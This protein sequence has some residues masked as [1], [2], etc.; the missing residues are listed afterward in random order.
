MSK[1][2]T[3]GMVKQQI[4]TNPNEKFTPFPPCYSFTCA[5]QFM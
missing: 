3:F 1:I 5:F 4:K 2:I